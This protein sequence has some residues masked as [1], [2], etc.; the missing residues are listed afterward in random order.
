MSENTVKTHLGNVYA[1]LGVGRRTE[2]LAA[3]QRLGLSH[4]SRGMPPP[5]NR[6]D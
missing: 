1:K 5:I 3:A 6:L 2:A 4:S